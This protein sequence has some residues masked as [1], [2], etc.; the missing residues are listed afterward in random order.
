MSETNVIDVDETTFEAD[1]LRRSFEKTVVVDFWAE[2]CGPCRALGP[3][4]ERL[5]TEEGADWILA[6]LDVDANQ[7]IAGAFGIQGI[8]AVKA[9]RDGKQVGE[10][11][12]AL[13]ESQ[14]R[15]WLEGLGPTE[16]DLAI[17]LAEEA[18]AAGRLDEAKDA[19]ERALAAEPGLFAA[20][21]GLA[22]VALAL[23]AGDLD[24]GALES[25]VEA[26]PGDLEAV[27]G[28]A[29]LE[30]AAGRHEPAFARL[31]ETIRVTS[32]D[33]REKVRK[34][35]LGL[36]DTLPADDARSLSARRDLSMALF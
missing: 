34:H 1:V 31:I 18:E 15:R 19:Y 14:V 22:R 27:L 9:F 8:P 3:V 4:L 21:S 13:P 17:V 6:K 28:L 32:G 36:F 24:A 7:R 29:D 2:W 5:A 26:D 20:R 35:L 23:R 16:G 25:R 33:D 11:T 10:F 12:G 30:A